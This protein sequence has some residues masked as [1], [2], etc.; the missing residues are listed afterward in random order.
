MT[1]EFAAPGRQVACLSL[2]RQREA[3]MTRPYDENLCYSCPMRVK[4]LEAAKPP[5]R[6]AIPPSCFGGKLPP[7]SGRNLPKPASIEEKEPLV[8]TNK[9]EQVFAKIRNTKSC[10]QSRIMQ[11]THIKT[12]ELS[13]IAK[14]LEAEGKIKIWPKGSRNM[15]ALP[16][17]PDPWA[18][19]TYPPRRPPE[20]KVAP[21]KAA[22]APEAKDAD[23][24]PGEGGA[25]DAAIK[26]LEA[27]RDQ[28]DR[29]IETLRAV[30]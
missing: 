19:E 25:I 28:I 20:K 7:G 9:K 2:M 29:A 24:V 21:R 12:E 4:R 3:G 27:R 17:Q 26:A 14:E 1:C 5:E 22:A 18:G 6:I 30:T 16:D 10:T 13:A 23:P 15:Y 8:A 11:Y